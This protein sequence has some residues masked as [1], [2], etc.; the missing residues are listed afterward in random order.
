MKDS[1]WYYR[2]QIASLRL[3]NGSCLPVQV[4]ASK[5]SIF[6]YKWLSKCVRKYCQPCDTG[7]WDNEHG[8]WTLNGERQNYPTSTGR[9]I[10]THQHKNVREIINKRKTTTQIIFIILIGGVGVSVCVCSYAL[11]IPQTYFPLNCKPLITQTSN[12]E[13]N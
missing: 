7:A 10:K 12:K 13:N 5:P 11:Y 1:K 2:K 9:Q 8:K 4:K 3:D 6:P